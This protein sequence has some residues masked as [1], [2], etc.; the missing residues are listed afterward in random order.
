MQSPLIRYI[1]LLKRWAWLLVLGVVLCGGMTYL[2]EKVSP[3]VYQA[4]AMIVITADTSSSG[5]VVASIAAEPT[6][7]QLLTNALVLKPVIA[8]HQGM[9]LEQLNAMVTVKP[10]P[11]TQLIELD[12]QNRNPTL[13]MQ[14]ANEICQSF[15]Q[16]SN[17]R[18]P[19]PVQ[20]LPAQEPET[21]IKPKPAQD[22]GIAALVG[23]S[24]AIALIIIFEWLED[25]PG[26]PEQVQESLGMELLGSI[27]LALRDQRGSGLK[28]TA[29]QVEKYRIVCG[30]LNVAQATWPFKL[31]MVTSALAGEGKTSVAANI[32]TFL[33][34]SGKHVLLVDA[35]LRHPSL[36]QHFQVN[37]R[38]GLANIFLGVGGQSL[39]ELSGQATSIPT[40]RVL[41]AGSMA[42]NP[43]ELLQSS[44]AHKLF[45]HYK[46]LSCDYVI[47]DAPPLL[48][49][50]DAQVMISLVEAVVLVIDPA[51]TSRRALLHV[52]QMLNRTRPRVTGAIINKSRWPDYEDSNMQ[53]R[54][55]YHSQPEPPPPSPQAMPVESLSH[56]STPGHEYPAIPTVRLSQV[57][58][59]RDATSNSANRRQGKRP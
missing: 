53:R 33:A 43:A 15:A 50:A 4:T 40:L 12:V 35:N 39:V 1:L 29:A 28:E 51:K 11:N 41:P 19:A 3:P 54:N 42:A 22:M 7:A 25:R 38:S 55:R 5:G 58:T 27:P 10:Q 18:L 24:L 21:P 26:T 20:I 14:L 48:P 6:Y 16:Y 13:A 37:S 52:R 44:L 9:T 8:Q 57:A 2:L 45:E 23:L 59:Q 34:K 47:F 31:V 17:S 30:N 46:T 56:T 36:Y 49:V 32:A